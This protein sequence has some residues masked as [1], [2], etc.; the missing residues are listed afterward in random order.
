M[1]NKDTDFVDAKPH[2]QLTTGEAIRMLRGLKLWTQEE[3]SKRSGISPTN[4]RAL[5]NDRIDM[6]NRPAEQ[7]A[8][9]FNIHP[10]ISARRSNTRRS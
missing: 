8:R 10:I 9:A 3:L 2:A 5:E 6:H 7:L 4:L 1:L